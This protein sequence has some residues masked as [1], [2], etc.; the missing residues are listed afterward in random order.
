VAVAAFA[1]FVAAVDAGECFF[2]G[3]FAK[4]ILLL[5]LSETI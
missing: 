4:A 5:L 2:S 3:P 1:A